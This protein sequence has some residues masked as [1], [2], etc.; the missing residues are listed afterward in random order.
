[1]ADVRRQI[2][3]QSRFVGRTHEVTSP[4]GVT[5]DGA[6]DLRGVETARGHALS[7]K[8]LA[9]ER[10]DLS[11]ARGSLHIFETEV[12]DSRFDKISA[13]DSVLDRLFVR[14]TFRTARLTGARI[15]RRLVDCDFTGASLR[16]ITLG[17][18]T[19]F[20]RC[21]FDGADLTDAKLTGARFVACTFADVR[22]SALTTFDRCDFGGALP[23]LGPAR[24]TR[25]TRDGVL[26]PDG[27]PGRADAEALERDYVDRYVRAVREGNAETMPLEPGSP[28][29]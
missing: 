6:V 22:F 27:W 1:M 19:V 23:D 7:V 20:E 14:C 29:H 28:P 11:H 15:G 18:N 3:E 13:A 25:C 16:R 21:V 8:Y 5:A 24:Q 26:L 2:V 9:L 12:T 17:E 10:L 4:Q